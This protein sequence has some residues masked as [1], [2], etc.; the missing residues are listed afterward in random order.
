MNYTTA[1]MLINEDIRVVN[2]IY[3][4]QLENHPE[5]PKTSFK[6]LDKKVSVGDYV[7][8]PSSTRHGFTV[9]QVA[10]V[11]IEVDF[12][13]PKEIKWLV[14]NIS[15]ESYKNV[16]QEEGK[17]IAALKESEKRKKRE[18]IKENML[19]MFNDVKQ[20]KLKIT[21]MKGK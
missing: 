12:E 7:I 16:I 13:S 5:Q 14:G 21:S 18:E 19:G 20:E 15:R 3:E 6:T 8:V 1:V 11:D 4:P 9:A 10:D 17:W 2:T